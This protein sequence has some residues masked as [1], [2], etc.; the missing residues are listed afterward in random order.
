MIKSNLFIAAFFTVA[1]LGLGCSSTQST[2]STEP[3]VEKTNSNTLRAIKINPSFNTRIES[4]PI[5]IESAKISSDT[6]ILQVSYGGGCVE[7]HGFE[8]ISRGEYAESFP[9]QLRLYF[10][11][12]NKNDMCKAIV[13]KTLYYDLKN[14]RLNGSKHIVLG[15][16]NWEGQLHYKY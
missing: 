10:L 8:L 9:E 14:I 4:S 2:V 13:R 3:K 15:I 1:L 11:H 12:D 16:N 6:L 7:E 5:S